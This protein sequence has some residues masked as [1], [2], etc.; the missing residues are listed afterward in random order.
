MCTIIRKAR[1][2]GVA[3]GPCFSYEYFFQDEEYQFQDDEEFEYDEESEEKGNKRTSVPTRRSTRT[4]VLNANGKREG[5]S[6][7]SWGGWKGERRS[8]RLGFQDP[9]EVERAPKRARTEEST[10]SAGSVDGNSVTMEPS[11]DEKSSAKVKVKATGAAALKPNEVAMEQI[12]GKKRSKFWVYA[13]E[14]SAAPSDANTRSREMDVDS[15]NG[16]GVGMDGET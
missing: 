7:S 5:S 13:V 16:H 15:M 11:I 6:E 14:P 8:A 12:A 10:T 4:A 1:Q 9:F 2:V 3:W